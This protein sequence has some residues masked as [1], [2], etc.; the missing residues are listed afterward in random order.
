MRAVRLGDW[1]YI[2]N[3][4][5]EFAFTTHID[6]SGNLGQ[7]AYF[8]SWEAAAQTNAEAAGIVKRY[9]SR[10]REELYNLAA[11]PQEQR[12][13]ASDPACAGQLK[14]L[15]RELDAWMREQNDAQRVFGHPRLL[16]DTTPFGP[17]APTGNAWGTAAKKGR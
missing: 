2:R 5:P 3:L 9:H 4:R 6:L 1:K 8:S 16:T 14:K 15:R 11:D 12:N 7:R 13:L 17:N 10:P